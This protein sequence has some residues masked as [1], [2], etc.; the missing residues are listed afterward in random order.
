MIGADLGLL[1]K[2]LYLVVQLGT[3]CV[4][5]SPALS[6]IEHTQ[7][8]FLGRNFHKLLSAVD[9]AHFLAHALVVLGM[10]EWQ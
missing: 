10:R 6:L 2:L 3:K 9:V 7:V 4:L 8:L 5:P 1:M